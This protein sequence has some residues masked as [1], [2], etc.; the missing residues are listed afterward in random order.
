M[1]L[2]T[3]ITLS[4]HTETAALQLYVV[5]SQPSLLRTGSRRFRPAK[6][7]LDTKPYAI[8]LSQVRHVPCGLAVV[9]ILASNANYWAYR[10]T[11]GDTVLQPPIFFALLRLTSALLSPSPTCAP[12]FNFSLVKSIA[13]AHYLLRAAVVP[14]SQAAVHPEG[15]STNA[16]GLCR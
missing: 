7:Q 2:R 12:H 11:N 9:S 10:S 13:A 6:A 4:I 3:Q 1:G 8:I 5:L 14:N 16:H 15:W